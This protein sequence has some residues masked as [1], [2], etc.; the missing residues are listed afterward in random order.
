MAKQTVLVVDDE[1]NIRELI[2]YNLKTEGFFVEEATTGEEALEAC[3]SKKPALVLLDIM[4]PGMDGLEVCTRLKRDAATSTIPI[5]MITAKSEEVDKVLGLELG[6]DDYI[7]KPFGVREM[8]ARVRALIRRSAGGLKHT[9]EEGGRLSAAG[10]TV[11]VRSYKAYRTDRPLQLTLKEFE[12]LSALIANRGKV[13][14]RDYLLDTIWGYEYFGETRTVDVHI[15]H[16]R[17]KLEDG[18]TVIETVR[19]VGYRFSAGKGE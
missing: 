17:K 4:L 7:T 14:T 3:V 12:L 15:R 6:A 5:I 11:D 10:I 13:L 2:A 16:L 9:G 8:L 18:G 1:A 19:G